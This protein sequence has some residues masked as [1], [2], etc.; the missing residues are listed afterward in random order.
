MSQSDSSSAQ[1]APACR[2]AFVGAGSMTREHL[3]A[4]ANLPNVV[5]AGLH[6]RTRARAESLAA[7]FSVTHVCDSIDELFES[8]RADLVVV[9]VP[10]LSTNMVSRQC[11]SHPWTALIEKPVGYDLDD[12]H[13]IASEARRLRRRAF[14]ALN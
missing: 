6:S 12:A 7:E 8:T 2:V 10:E 3:R 13:A 9:S 14:V 5:L 1:P 4:F 11:F